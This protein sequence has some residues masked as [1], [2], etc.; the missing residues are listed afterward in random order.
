MDDIKDLFDKAKENSEVLLLRNFMP[1]VPTWD[2]F[3]N[4]LYTKST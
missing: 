3:I 4:N 1:D 2:S